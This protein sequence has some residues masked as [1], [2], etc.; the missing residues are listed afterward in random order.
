M[1]Q[2]GEALA[3]ATASRAGQRDAAPLPASARPTGPWT[4][5]LLLCAVVLGCLLAAA[6]AVASV[7]QRQAAPWLRSVISYHTMYSR[8]PVTDGGPASGLAQAAAL[9]KALHDQQ[10]LDLTVP[11]LRAQG[12]QFARAQQLQ[13]DG[14][15]VLQLVYLPGRGAP[16]APCLMPAAS[17]PERSLTLDVQQALA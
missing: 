2:A 12:L 15:S 4:L 9:R 11:D 3:W 13:F 10:G 1:P 6:A 7:Q 14:R 17:Q 5:L 8:E 16:V